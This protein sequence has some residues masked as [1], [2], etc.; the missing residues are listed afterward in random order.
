MER[1]LREGNVDLNDTN[2][3]GE[4]HFTGWLVAGTTDAGLLRSRSRC[5]RPSCSPMWT[6]TPRAHEAGRF[7]RSHVKL[8]AAYEMA[9]LTVEQTLLRT[10]L[11]QRHWPLIE[12]LARETLQYTSW[13]REGDGPQRQREKTLL[14]ACE[15]VSVRIDAD[16]PDEKGHTQ[17]H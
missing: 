17:L 13:L 12:R 3:R 7:S 1:L 4:F 6:C 11:K 14:S 2:W 8:S 10:A 5:S 16:E 15:N 9:L